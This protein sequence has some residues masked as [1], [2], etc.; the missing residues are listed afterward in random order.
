MT[1]EP[2]VVAEKPV[3]PNTTNKLWVGG[4]AGSAVIVINWALKTWAKVEMP[5]EVAMAVST[6]ITLV[7]AHLTPVGEDK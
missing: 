2:V 3:Q 4:A 1:D 6:I 7:A 5:T